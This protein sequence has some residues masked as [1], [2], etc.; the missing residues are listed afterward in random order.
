M[1]SRGQAPRRGDPEPLGWYAARC[2]ELPRCARNGA[3]ENPLDILFVLCSV[4]GHGYRPT[5][6]RAADETTDGQPTRGS[7][8]GEAAPAA[9]AAP[10]GA[11]RRSGGTI[12]ND[13]AR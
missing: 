2:S 4:F 12:W 9:Q 7:Q 11:R 6:S 10:V 13:R 1:A 5:L 3:G 8:P